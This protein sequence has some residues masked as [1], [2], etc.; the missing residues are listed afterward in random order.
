LPVIIDCGFQDLLTE[1]EMVSL[2]T[3]LAYCHNINKQFDK[4]TK[5]TIT[6]FRDRLKERLDKYAAE[7]W[8][9]Q[10]VKGHYLD[11][12]PK[13]RFV[14]LSGDATEEIHELDPT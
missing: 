3:Q 11:L 4:P 13:E 5:L 9:I 2:S 10:L 6:G 1:K 14:Y 12:Y 7:N 8:G